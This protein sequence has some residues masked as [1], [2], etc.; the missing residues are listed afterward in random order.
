M[1]VIVGQ[2]N[3]STFE[4]VIYKSYRPA[5]KEINNNISSAIELLA[6]S[7]ETNKNVSKNKMIEKDLQMALN[8]LNKIKNETSLN[9]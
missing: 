6:N 9:I 3:S 5:Y 8:L 2:K 7:V 1:I 4:K